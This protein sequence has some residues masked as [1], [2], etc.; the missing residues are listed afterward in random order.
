LGVNPGAYYGPAKRWFPDRYAAVADAL[1]QEFGVRTVIFGSPSDL[2]VAKEVAAK[3]KK[4]PVLLTGRTSLGQL[5]ALIR[6]CRLLITNDSGPMHL[7]AA[8]D[9]PQL[10]IFGSTSEVATGPLSR[11]ALVIKQQVD[12][13]PCFLRECPTDFRCMK[14]IP[15]ERVL[16]EAR[17]ILD[18]STATGHA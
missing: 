16:E 18:L 11:E 12:C 10:A 5:M 3:M 15:V 8:L 17:K 2:P 14:G 7:A 13:N 1:Q 6:R 4:P 9:V